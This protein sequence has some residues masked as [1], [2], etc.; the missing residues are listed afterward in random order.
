MFQKSDYFDLTSHLGQGASRKKNS[1]ETTNSTTLSDILHEDLRGM[2]QQKPVV[3]DLHGTHF[4]YDIAQEDMNKLEDQLLRIATK[5]LQDSQEQP[6]LMKN[7]VDELR[8]RMS[9]KKHFPDSV[10]GDSVFLNPFVDR[11][12]Y[13]LE[14]YTAEVEFQ[15]A[16]IEVFVFIFN[17]LIMWNVYS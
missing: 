11:S 3:C 14:L 12:Q 13:L 9:D 17:I 1:S 10:I 7:Y 2:S 4:I 6:D 15:F 5:Y 16:K 8:F